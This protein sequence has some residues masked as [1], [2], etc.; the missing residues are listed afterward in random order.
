MLCFLVF[1]EYQKIWIKFSFCLSEQN[2]WDFSVPSVWIF[3]NKSHLFI[4]E[5]KVKAVFLPQ[6]KWWLGVVAPRLK[7]P[8]SCF[9]DRKSGED[10]QELAVAGVV[11]FMPSIGKVMENTTALH[12]CVGPS[13]HLNTL[14]LGLPCAAQ[15][16][17]SC[18]CMNLAFTTW[19][20]ACGR[21]LIYTCGMIYWH[22]SVVEL[23]LWSCSHWTCGQRQ[24]SLVQIVPREKVCAVTS[25][26]RD[27]WAHA[28][29]AEGL[30]PA[31]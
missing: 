10:R 24:L 21:W 28:G 7:L 2:T 5:V 25:T 30:W 11:I 9:L 26:L 1:A 3:S 12:K 14:K 19:V 8:G 16:C 23:C 20:Q 13:K 4:T 18:G 6:A 31:C 15:P 22:I 29:G 17:L 27:V